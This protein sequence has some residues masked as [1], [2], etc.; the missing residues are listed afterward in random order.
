M[1][2][3][4]FPPEGGRR[5]P[6][7]ALFWM[8]FH[9][10]LAAA[11]GLSLAAAGA[12]RVN[13]DLFGILPS[14]RGSKFAAA[15]MLGARNSR[16]VFIL[17]ESADFSR[18]KKAAVLFYDALA[19]SGV[20]EKLRLYVDEGTAQFLPYLYGHRYVLLDR[21]TRERLERGEAGEIAQEALAVAFGALT[22]TGLEALEGDPF[23]LTEREAR[24]F[25]SLLPDLNGSLGPREGVLA[26]RRGERWYVMIRGSLPPEGVSLTGDKN[27]VQK[28][29]ALSGQIMEGDGEVRF[30]Y[31]GIPFHS[32]ESSAAARREISL[33]ST[34]S[35]ILILLLFLY[36]FRSP[37]PALVSAAALGVS[38]LTAA[39]S[40]L[41]FFR[42]VHVLTF[43]FGTTLIGISVDYSIHYFVHVHPRPQ[44]GP[45]LPS[46]LFRGLTMSFVSSELCFIA[47]FFAPFPILKQFA[48][49]QGTGLLSSYL[50]VLCLYPF[51]KNK[52]GDERG[53]LPPRAFRLLS[54]EFLRGRGRFVKTL[55]LSALFA[56]ALILLFFNRSLLRIENHIGALYTMSK[57]L[58]ESEKTAAAVLRREAPAW[59]FMVSGASEEELL[60]NEERLTRRLEKEITGGRL[61]GCLGVSDF[62]PSLNTQARNYAAAA[63]LLP[64]AEAQFEALGFPPE[65]AAAY[66]RD[67]AGAAGNYLLPGGDLSPWQEEFLSHLWIGERE[68]RYY[69]CVLPLGG[70]DEGFFRN[71][72][73]ELDFVFLLNPVRDIGAGLDALT[74][75]MLRLLP[76]AYII[77]AGVIFFAYPR[78]EALR[79]LGAP[80]LPILTALA[81][82]AAAGI[83]PQFFSVVGLFMVFGLGLDYGFYMIEGG[84]SFHPGPAALGIGVSFAT[85]ALSFGALILSGFAPVHIL[86]LTVFTGLSAAFISAMLLRTRVS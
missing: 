34:L 33:I 58:E 63:G 82:P 48:L 3:P 59:Y 22:L 68:G 21:E 17:V 78:R 49:F 71:I 10:S 66:R 5:R 65:S 72:E 4:V 38:I 80:V 86:G 44:T 7:R 19:G 25:L 11:L 67:F 81:V 54:A 15:A 24:R 53:S 85:T 52:K 12:P 45:G 37:L 60:A 27:G 2:G 29:Y 75:I 79:L 36:V 61:K 40:V 42:E 14:F 35:V 47:L 20:F 64:Y 69:S 30:V 55:L 62:L 1:K 76:A 84:R 18:A 9:A 83:P 73:E 32:R 70:A 77:I 28:I 50:S 26:S 46:P 51:I 41:L 31:S 43:V 13:R 56:A 6:P 74:R 8:L 16:Q 23:L 57:V 39:A